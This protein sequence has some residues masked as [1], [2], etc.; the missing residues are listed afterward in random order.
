M[1]LTFDF[2]LTCCCGGG[3]V[4]AEAEEAVESGEDDDEVCSC[5]IG[6]SKRTVRKG[7]GEL[8]L[9]GPRAAEEM[10][11]NI[12]STREESSSFSGRRC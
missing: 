2:L 7:G 11:E 8:G 5:T 3:S 4:V 12:E 1:V 6:W 9:T 10:D